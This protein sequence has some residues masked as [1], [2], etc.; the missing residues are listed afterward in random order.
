MCYGRVTPENTDPLAFFPRCPACGLP[1]SLAP[2]KGVDRDAD[3]QLQH[4]RRWCKEPGY[5]DPAGR[6]GLVPV[7]GPNA[8]R[9]F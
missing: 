6:H 2:E 1:L 5:V 9:F 8:A 7:F 4:A 3:G